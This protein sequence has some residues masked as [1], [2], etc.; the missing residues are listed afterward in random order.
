MTLPTI[1]EINAVMS[2]AVSK[3]AINDFVREADATDVSPFDLYN[4]FDLKTVIPLRKVQCLFAAQQ[5]TIHV[6][7]ILTTR[8]DGL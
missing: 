1:K 5:G 8:C 6:R 7:K 3:M 2:V 4:A